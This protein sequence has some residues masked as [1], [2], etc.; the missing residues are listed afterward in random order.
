MR[1]AIKYG[2]AC[3]SAT[4]RKRQYISEVNVVSDS[5]PGNFKSTNHAIL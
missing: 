2:L 4:V 3:T 5:S 1:A